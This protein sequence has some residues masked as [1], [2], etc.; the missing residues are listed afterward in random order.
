[1]RGMCLS[2]EN[3]LFLGI[4]L[5]HT[6]SVYNKPAQEVAPTGPPGKVPGLPRL[7]TFVTPGTF[8]GGPCRVLA[9]SQSPAGCKDVV[10]MYFGNIFCAVWMGFL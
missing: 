2:K 5:R 4:A 6:N 10:R 8:L 3:T 7:R 1:M 9:G